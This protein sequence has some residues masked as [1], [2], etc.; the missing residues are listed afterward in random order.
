MR[1][2]KEIQRARERRASFYDVRLA[3]AAWLHA[4]GDFTEGELR[5]ENDS[6]L[7]RMNDERAAAKAAREAGRPKRRAQG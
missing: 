2:T 4:R 6:G 5:Y 3:A 1:P 7:K